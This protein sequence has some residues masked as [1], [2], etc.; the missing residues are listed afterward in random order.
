MQVGIGLP[1]TVPGT[2]GAT[3]CEWARRA[4]AGPFSTLGVLDRLRYD[5]VDPFVA[6]AAAAAVTERIGLA[7]TIA[8]GPLRRAAMLAKE[9]A[10]V[11]AL[12]PGRM[13][14][15][16]AVG[17]RPDDYEVAEAAYENR[18]T[19]LSRELAYLRGPFDSA[20]IGPATKFGAGGIPVLIGGAG[21]AALTRMA[22]YADG[23]VHGGGPPRAFAS[24]A[25]KARAAWR[26]LDR[27]GEP[28]LW[29]QGYVALGDA[30]RGRDYLLDYYAFTGPFAARIAA[31]VLTD[32]DSVRDFVRGYAGEGCD[33]L[34]L[35][36]TTGDPDEVDRLAEILS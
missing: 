5:S 24:A 12:A 4:D 25:T 21:G 8:I 9:A 16:L 35:F 19:A 7:T 33:E 26:D 29:G 1:S 3:L 14:L 17:A 34:L 32:A 2:T 18:G 22:R 31:G 36:P 15:G 10:S 6:L 23:Y 28:V 13:T 20:G 27:P 30:D 11:H